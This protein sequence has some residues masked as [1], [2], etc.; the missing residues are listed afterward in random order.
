MLSGLISV[1]Q[2]DFFLLVSRYGDKGEYSR[3]HHRKSHMV[4]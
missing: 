3:F 2:G 1:L 4:F